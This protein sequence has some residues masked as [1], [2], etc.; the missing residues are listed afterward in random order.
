MGSPITFDAIESFRDLHK[1]SCQMSS[2]DVR[3]DR[4]TG[5]PSRVMFRC[6][7]CGAAL[8]GTVSETDLPRLVDLYKPGR[9][10]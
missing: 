5:A 9:C 4:R 6:P 3:L 10:G 8:M 2:P 7:A 1:A